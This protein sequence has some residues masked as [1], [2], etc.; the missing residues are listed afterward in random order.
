VSVE[1]IVA[2][3]EAEAA[4]EAAG[5]VASARERAGA[6]VAAAE[7]AM[8]ARVREACAAAEP[9]I[10]AEAMRQVNAARVRA[11]ERQAARTAELMDDVF[12]TA[13]AQLEAIVDG[14]SRGRWEAAVARLVEE[15]AVI[16]GPGG[17]IGVRQADMAVARTAAEAIGCRVEEIHA[18]GAPPAPLAAGVVGRSADGRIEVDASLG[19]R[20]SRARTDL[21]EPIAR[22]LGVGG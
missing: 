11:L 8:A 17:V 16:V 7:A 10:R 1:A 22:L 19:A 5:I 4:E 20:L 12:R 6:S 9:T 18:D 2:V 3:I 13:A 15:T 21:A 14:P